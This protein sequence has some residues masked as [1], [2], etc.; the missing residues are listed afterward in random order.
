MEHLTDAATTLEEVEL[1]RLLGLAVRTARQAGETADAARREGVSIASTKSNHLDVVTRADLAAED[2]IKESILAVRPDDGFLG[3]ETEEIHSSDGITWLVDPIDGTVNYMYGE[4]TYAISIAAYLGS[5]PLAGVVYSPGLGELWSARHGGGAALNG[6]KVR[7]GASPSAG[8]PL[9]GTVF[10]YAAGARTQQMRR[11]ADSA[12]VIRDVRVSGSTALDLCR[13]AAGRIDVF[14]T[15]SVNWWDVAAGVL[16]AREAGCRV[17]AQ[18]DPES[19]DVGC[20]VTNPAVADEV[21]ASLGYAAMPAYGLEAPA[22][23]AV[24]GGVIETGASSTD[25]VE[26]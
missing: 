22:N 12:A 20:I 10:G 9:L 8:Q 24:A 16:I 21:I 1:D 4:A 17:W 25:G 18:Q 7:T 6:T 2:F 5:V 14:C 15:D 19:G 11:L 26:E 13:V 23:K 3:E